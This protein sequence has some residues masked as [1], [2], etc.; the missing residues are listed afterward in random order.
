[1][2]LQKFPILALVAI[3][4]SG[5]SPAFG[6][7][8]GHGGG[9]GGG[10]H[11][12]FHGGHGFG[13]ARGFGGM[14]HGFAGNRGFGPGFVGER[15]RF[16]HRFGPSWGSGWGG[17]TYVM[18]GYPSY[19]YAYPNIYEPYPTGYLATSYYPVNPTDVPAYVPQNCPTPV[20]GDV[21]GNVQR[22]LRYRGFYRGPIDGLSGPTTRAA[23]R[24]YDVSVGLP[25]NGA[26][27]ARLLMSMGIM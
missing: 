19:P 22:V 5:F 9:R 21:V 20:S 24:A 23:I 14:R 2:R 11:G 7:G 13:G 16:G 8:G 17:N 27:D 4:L 10:G 12:G 25:P 1:M 18:N 26:I 3:L 6:F 15:F